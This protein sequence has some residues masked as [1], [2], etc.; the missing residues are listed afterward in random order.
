MKMFD[1]PSDET[2]VCLGDGDDA[3]MGV[4][5]RVGTA[6]AVTARGR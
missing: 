1:H 4:R 5:K 3:T 2:S 6:L